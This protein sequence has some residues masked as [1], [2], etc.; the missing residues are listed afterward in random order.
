MSSNP[1]P[2]VSIIVP[3]YNTARYVGEA[4]DSALAQTYSQCEIVAID[5][6]STDESA[7][8]LDRYAAQHPTRFTAIHQANQGLG[9]TRMNGIAVARGDFI[10]SLDADDRLHPDAVATWIAY[11]QAHPEFSVVYSFWQR[12]DADG[13]LTGVHDY[14]LYRPGEPLEGHI[15]PTML[16]S[17]VVAATSLIDKAAL[18]AVGGYT[19]EALT[20]IA[21]QQIGNDRLRIEDY[22]LYLRLLLAGYAFG[23]VPQALFDYRDTPDSMSKNH[24]AMHM[25]QKVVLSALIDEH[26]EAMME[27]WFIGHQQREAHL[28]ATWQANQDAIRVLNE[29]VAQLE[30]ALI[31]KE[32]ELNALRLENTNYQTEFTE[33]AQQLRAMLAMVSPPPRADAPGTISRKRSRKATL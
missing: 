7:A 26:R 25:D 19:S 13:T 4:L 11:Q 12:I 2:L 31:V 15:L 18:L 22:F 20:R 8:I 30:A 28:G 21:F 32:N 17:S 6:G 16:V 29:R 3:C 9:R 14:R 24:K 10:V 27:G 5:D 1:T 33:L 23:F